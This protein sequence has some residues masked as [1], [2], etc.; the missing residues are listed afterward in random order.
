MKKTI[1]NLYLTFLCKELAML[2][3]AGLT[4]NESVRIL[5]EDEP[6]SDGKIVLQK[7]ID[8]L[9]RGNKFSSA[10]E[11]CE[12]FPA[13]MIKMIEIG[14]RTGRIEQ[15]LNA[16]AEYYD[17]QNRLSVTIK[18]S[19]LYPAILLVLMVAVVLIL[20]VQVLPI[21]SDVFGR[22]GTQMSPL[23]TALMDFGTW[24]SGAAVVIA[25]IV[26][27]MLLFAVIVLLS[28]G[29][30]ESI[31]RA[32]LN[33]WGSRGVFGKVAS[34]RY[35]Y[36]MTLA[37]AS[38]LD[39]L[40]AVDISASAGGGSNTVDQMHRKCRKMVEDG[41]P[42]HE[43]LVKSGVLSNQDGK[44]LA[45]GVKSGKSDIAMAEIA[46]RSD[47]DVTENIDRVIGRIEPTLVIASSVIIGVILLS[48]MLPL[49]GI[50]TA[51]G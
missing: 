2:V 14:E 48:V 27:V 12:V 8:E 30:R 19:V 51:L 21:F 43:A 11:N 39:T 16:L 15:T 50:M 23:A 18:K 22:L 13:Y 44:M 25:A 5:L 6:S 41:T 49:M 31:K 3:D 45:I 35:V 38:G 37:M 42:L 47:I 4:I 34:S 24:F 40:D 32:F 20:I 9:E 7:V 33:K 46:R 1:S 17:R 36:A 10:L 26:L 28:P 29:L